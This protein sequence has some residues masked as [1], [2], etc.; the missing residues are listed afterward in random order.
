[1]E[2]KVSPH[3]G[4]LHP[5]IIYPQ[6]RE[7]SQRAKLSASWLPNAVSPHTKYEYLIPTILYLRIPV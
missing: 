4:L 6:N 2:I 7:S 3:Q 1:M 5:N